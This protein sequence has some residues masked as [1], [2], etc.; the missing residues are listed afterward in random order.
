MA[1]KWYNDS[2]EVRTFVTALID[3]EVLQDGEDIK[4]A[5]SH[6]QRYN[7]EYNAWAENGYPTEGDTTWDDFVDAVTTEDEDSED[8]D[9]DEDADSE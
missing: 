1:E 9:E 4:A 2:N 3:A 5:L 8:E 7:D 6:P